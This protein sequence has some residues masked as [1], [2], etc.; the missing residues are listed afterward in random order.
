MYQVVPERNRN[1]RMRTLHRNLL[2]PCD[3]LPFEPIQQLEPKRLHKSPKIPEPVDD[4]SNHEQL[5][6]E[7][8][9]EDELIACFPPNVPRKRSRRSHP[10]TPVKPCEMSS[11]SDPYA[12]N[13]SF[14]VEQEQVVKP[15]SINDADT[16]N[17]PFQSPAASFVTSPSPDIHTRPHRVIRPPE[18]LQYATLGSPSS[19]PVVNML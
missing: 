12:T 15:H 9:S 2:L 8:S 5:Q 1:G 16:R 10:P 4:G 17:T 11:G 19:F 3:E 13:E 6:E 7:L 14:S 18:H